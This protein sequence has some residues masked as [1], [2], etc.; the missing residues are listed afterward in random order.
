MLVADPAVPQDEVRQAGGLPVGLDELWAASDLVTLHCPSNAHTRRMVNTD[1]ITKMKPGVVLV[2]V[3]RGDL[4][5][6]AALVEALRRCHVSAAALD[7]WDPEPVPADSPL[8]TMGNVIVT[9]HVASVS[10]KA[11]RTLRES[12]AEAAARAIRG[13]AP[14]NVV[15]GVAGYP[16]SPGAA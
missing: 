2:N 9:P 16:R 15:N 12:A 13:E 1:S 5:D 4:V 14:V 6:P 7:V 10:A 11:V 3:G 8:L